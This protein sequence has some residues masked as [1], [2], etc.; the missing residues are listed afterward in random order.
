MQQLSGQS[1]A[2]T[3]FAFTALHLR[4]KKYGLTVGIFVNMR[5]PKLERTSLSYFGKFLQEGT[6]GE[7]MGTLW[8]RPFQN[9]KNC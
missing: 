3:G 9:V 6:P 4:E 1:I 7:R 2:A 5:I 8:R